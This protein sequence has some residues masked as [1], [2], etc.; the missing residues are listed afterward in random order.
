MND[1]KNTNTFSRLYITST[2][3]K[4]FFHFTRTSNTLKFFMFGSE[5]LFIGVEK[6]VVKE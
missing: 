2:T 6:K 4:Q 1:I 3:L 5:N